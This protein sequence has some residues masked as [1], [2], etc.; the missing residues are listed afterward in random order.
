MPLFARCSSTVPRTGS[1]FEG[2]LE[3]VEARDAVLPHLPRELERLAGN[4][5]VGDLH[6]RDD[7]PAAGTCEGDGGSDDHCAEDH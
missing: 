1:G 7:R 3:T 4:P 5:G 2:R 6:D